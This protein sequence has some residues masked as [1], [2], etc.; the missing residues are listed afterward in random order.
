MEK[1]QK[2]LN[3]SK[4]KKKLAISIRNNNTLFP[5][6]SK[7]NNL[8]TKKY[9]SNSTVNSNSMKIALTKYRENNLLNTQ[10]NNN[11]SNY[12]NSSI[13]T[14]NVT[15]TNNKIF[16]F[17]KSLLNQAEPK[18]KTSFQKIE[19]KLLKL[20]SKE[21]VNTNDDLDEF[22]ICNEKNLI[23]QEHK[24]YISDIN[25]PSTN[26]NI[27]TTIYDEDSID[28]DI[29]TEEEEEFNLNNNN[30]TDRN[31]NIL[32]IGINLYDINFNVCVSIE[33]LFNELIKDLEINKMNKF[34]H[35]LNIV[36]NFLNIFNDNNNHN[37]FLTFDIN[38][39]NNSVNQKLNKNNV[40]ENIFLL[41]K[42]Y[43]IQQLIFFYIIILIGLIKNDS[44]KKIYLSGIQNLSFHFHQN[45]QVFNFILT[46]R[47][48][49]NNISL[50]SSEQKESY[51]KC[52]NMVKEN[53]TW[54]N[55][56]NFMKCLQI[57]NKMTKRV[58]KNLFE[59][60]RLYFNANPYFNSK[61]I[62][63]SK[64]NNLSLDK[65]KL[66][67]EHNIKSLKSISKNKNNNANN[68]KPFSN[69][70]K[71]FIDSDIN[72]LLEYIKFYK[73]IKFTNLLK[74]LKYSPSI[75]YLTDKSK[76]SDNNH[77]YKTF[78]IKTSI[79]TSNSHSKDKINNS[80]RKN[81]IFSS[82]TPDKSQPKAPFLKPID[83]K[84]KYTL[85][86]DLDETL[87]FYQPNKELAHIQIRPGAEDF[88]KQLSEFYEII[89]FSSSL[90]TYADIVID[91]IDTE[92]KIS[93]RLYNQHTMDF[94]DIKIK[95]L[96]KLGRDLKK[97]IIV[98]NYP[99]NYSLQPK[100]GINIID[101]KGNKN[102]DILEYLKNDLIKLAKLNP[103]DV[104]YYLKEIQINMNKRGN[105]I[106]NNYNNRLKNEKIKCNNNFKMNKNIENRHK[107]EKF[108][109]IKINDTSLEAINENEF[110]NTLISDRIENE[111]N[112][113][114]NNNK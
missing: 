114:K 60:I 112:N 76:L 4:E 72:L 8:K 64:K 34:N 70:D 50:L 33:N 101:F 109:N 75:N 59:Q 32:N 12:T 80:K 45:F 2:N 22:K 31:K 30:L 87:V 100:N 23:N 35:K 47:V 21:Q 95:D 82:K 15:K 79:K 16:K 73:N 66:K 89:I 92:N 77:N 69:L 67:N 38:S 68:I 102:D 78:Q 14:C 94:G 55:E 24:K 56:N 25:T 62:Y 61:D 58:I 20:S 90:Q 54:L 48:N 29:N 19:P 85:V 83:P 65:N 3:K 11:V 7:L 57:N 86:L 97:V 91:G 27:D 28:F 6:N 88:I 96:A 37:L 113:I 110:E 1:N 42:E 98:D 107:K 51:D 46:T 81:K 10:N 41:I 49:K 105:E 63:E 74:E 108:K 52:I 93:S 18:T 53:R 5:H 111:N 26:V 106:I 36:N 9:F 44:E 43:L 84:Y 104:R 17:D 71:D 99:D 40:N 13:S 103:D 39:L